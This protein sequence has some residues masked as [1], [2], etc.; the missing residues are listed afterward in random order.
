MRLH[1]EAV[2]NLDKI[3]R[4]IRTSIEDKA[5]EIAATKQHDEATAED[6]SEAATFVLNR[7]YIDR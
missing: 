5:K 4:N 1:H 7:P 2:R 6:L 3:I